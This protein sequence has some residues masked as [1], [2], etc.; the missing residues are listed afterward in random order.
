MLIH[1]K[2]GP[3]E[4]FENDE[5]VTSPI[6]DYGEYSASECGFYAQTGICLDHPSLFVDMGANIGWFSNFLVKYGYFDYALAFEPHP[7][8]FEKLCYNIRLAGNIGKVFPINMAV[9][10]FEGKTKLY[11]YGPGS[12][13]QT[14]ACRVNTGQASL[15]EDQG[16]GYVE[17]DVTT[18]D[19]A[20]RGYRPSYIKMDV[21]GS[22]LQVIKGG[23]K[24]L[25]KYK[26]ICSFEADRQDRSPLV[27]KYVREV[28]GW[29]V[30]WLRTPHLPIK[31]TEALGLKSVVASFNALMVPP[32]YAGSYDNL[33]RVE[34]DDVYGEVDASGLADYAYPPPAFK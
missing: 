16:A 19:K 23:Q 5:Y 3:Q 33:T 17:V 18:M 2:I 25:L 24:T 6:R 9:S 30:R 27:T 1:S 8:V 32:Q 31:V 29:D 15:T 14:A 4:V 12:H 13:L 7:N 21:E 28:M 10:D 20:L 22:E 26:P 34:D 11:D